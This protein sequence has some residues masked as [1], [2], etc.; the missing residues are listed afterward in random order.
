[1][2]DDSPPR[3]ERFVENMAVF[4][5]VLGFGVNYLTISALNIAVPHIQSAL[6]ASISH[7]Q[8]LLDIYILVPAVLILVGG[9]LGDRYGRV[10]WYMIGQVSFVLGSL[11]SG[12]AP[13]VEWLIAF[14]ALQGLGAALIIPTSLAIINS[15]VA[16]ERLGRAM[17]LWGM[18]LP[19]VTM[20]G[21]VVGGW[22]VDNFSW[23]AAFFLTIPF[24]ILAFYLAARYVPESFDEQATGSLDWPGALTLMV[25]LGG[26]LF[27][28]IE[29]P[30]MGWNNPW[31][32]GTVVI[33]ILGLAAFILVEARS[34]APM[35][36]LH[37]FRNR[38]FTGINLM[39]FFT[40]MG[41]GIFLFVSLNLQQVQGYTAFL[42]GLAFLPREIVSMI[43][44]RTSGILTDRIGPIRPLLFGAFVAMAGYLLYMRP[45]I[46]ANYWTTFLPAM[47]VTAVGMGNIVVP[48][49]AA[50]VAALPK[51]YSGIASGV[52][53]GVTRVGQ[54]LGIA[55]F[56]TA[57]SLR[58][59][60]ALTERTANIALDAGGRAELMSR[61]VNLGATIP[62]E[63]LSPTITVAVEEAIRWAFVDAFR[64]LL[65]L[66]ALMMFIS[67]VILLA[68]VPIKQPL[69]QDL[70]AE[71]AV[72]GTD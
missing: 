45:G 20:I 68:F 59:Q 52:K 26:L 18:M 49:T 16:P 39:T 30:N 60:T 44:S 51:R 27:G 4:L 12:V 58:F 13:S 19:V 40:Y 8:W 5:A 62:P 41:L 61:A 28:I 33:G 29:G 66:G 53:T 70:A 57:M 43:A 63:G 50:A 72:P 14:R 34:R 56:G 69:Q 38:T 11:A 42:A 22:L 36:P 32:V 1:M 31:I 25:G 35:L 21:P 17:G 24:S 2:T 7:V 37:L 9:T 65:L 10:R 71:T 67:F 15:T 23:R 46:E 54:M 6:N 3:S 48:Q 47:I 55:I 64:D